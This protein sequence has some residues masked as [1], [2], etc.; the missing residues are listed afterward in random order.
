M[1][2]ETLRILRVNSAFAA[3]FD[4][5]RDGMEGRLLHEVD[6]GRWNILGLHQ[7]LRAVLAN[8]QPLDDWEI[9]LDSLRG[10]RC[11]R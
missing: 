4:I 5:P 7:R 2:D 3:H 6:G 9:T 1:L 11:C 8:A 10:G